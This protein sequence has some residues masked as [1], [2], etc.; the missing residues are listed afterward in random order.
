MQMS[1]ICNT[2]RIR[3]S[4]GTFRVLRG[5]HRGHACPCPWEWHP[6]AS[7]AKS[8]SGIL[9][10]LT[11]VA[12][13]LVRSD[14][15]IA[16]HELDEIPPSTRKTKTEDRNWEIAQGWDFPLC[17]QRSWFWFFKPRLGG[18]QLPITPALQNFMP[19][20]SEATWTQ[21]H[22]PTQ[23][24]VIKNKI[25]KTENIKFWREFESHNLTHCYWRVYGCTMALGKAQ[26]F[27]T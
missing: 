18:S 12:L 25:L 11:H 15:R 19:L 10:L 6:S 4:V 14:K 16:S 1:Q 20:A 21:V 26:K 24:S 23:E 9:S 5:R 22:I 7:E 8:P 2:Y 3:S 13:L 27:L 17:F